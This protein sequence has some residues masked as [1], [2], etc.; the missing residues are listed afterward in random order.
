MHPNVRNRIEIRR[1]QAADRE[2]I[3]ELYPAAFPKED[4]LPLLRELW[5]EQEN[6]FSFV[7]ISD[8]RLVGHTVFTMCRIAGRPEK[9]GLLGPVAV[10]PQ[11][12]RQGIGSALIQEGFT[13]LKREGAAQ[14][15][16]LG[17]PG[18]YGRFGFEPDRNVAPPFELP[19]EWQ[20]AWQSISLRGVMS[21]LYGTLSVPKPWRQPT[22]WAP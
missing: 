2:A 3:E 1:S 4:L 15:Y 11:R 13:Q 19:E 5:S 6:I 12:Q 22:L 18:Y 17:D 20:M 21:K 7:A 14:V 9:V 10:A 16:V 8:E